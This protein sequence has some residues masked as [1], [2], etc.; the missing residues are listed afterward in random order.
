MEKEK[1]LIVEDEEDIRELLV[2]NLKKRRL[3]CGRRFIRRRGAEKNKTASL[4]LWY[5][6]SD[7]S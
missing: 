4:I 3:S 5:F 2:Y 7:A 1:I 6:R